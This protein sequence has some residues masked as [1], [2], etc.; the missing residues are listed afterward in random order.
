MGGARM[1]VWICTTMCNF[2]APLLGASRLYAYAKKQGFDI[3]LKDLNQD[4]Y[5]TL[6]SRDYLE[7][8]L[9]RASYSIDSVFQN[10]YVKEDLGSIIL[11]SSN[12]A[13]RQLLAKGIMLNNSWYKYIQNIDI[14]KKPMFGLINSKIK[15][16]NILYAL[17]SEREFFL[18]E[19][20]RSRQIIDEK[21]LSL[22]SDE[23][24]ENFNNLLCGKALIDMVHFPAMFDFG[25]GLQGTA[26]APRTGDVLRAVEDE[27]HNFLIPY[28]RNKVLPAF[29]EEQPELVG[30]SITC[31]YEVIPALTLANMIKKV[32]P[33]THVVLG[34]I[35]TTQLAERISNNKPLWS[36]FDSL[37]L[38]P[39][40]V[41][42][43]ELINQ[44]EKKSDFSAVPNL[45]WKEKGSI[46]KSEKTHEFDI[47]EACAPEFVSVRPNSGL[48]L[49]TASGC[50]WGKCIFCDYPTT[51]TADLDR[52]HFK[53][54]V[55]KME[56]VLNDIRELK[57]KY[58]P[59]MI[60]ITDSSMHPKRLEAIAE[61]NLRSGKM[62][63]FSA[64]FRTEKE[65]KSK[66]FCLKLKDGGFLGGYVGLESGSQRV[67]DI[68]NK[69]IDL[70]DTETIIKNFHDTDILLHIFSIIG[71]PGETREDAAMT[72]NFFKR[73]HRWLK[74]DWIIY[75]LYVLE[76]SPIAKRAAELGV[77]IMPLPDDYLTNATLYRTES[78]LSQDESVS[79]AIGFGEKLKKYW[80]PL[81]EIMDVESMVLFLLG[82]S[83][84]GIPPDKIKNT[85]IK[86]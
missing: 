16:D 71:I 75:Y 43:T 20:E 85:G 53:K 36:M 45:I 86:I 31:V 10:K 50:Y 64:L 63:K 15:A 25:L 48:P 28:Y 13:V 77:E 74:L 40:E 68:I 26:Y 41:A 12:Q 14:L 54:R 79:L 70:N 61:D 83:A 57:E 11:N 62:V 51:G 84:K 80:H 66:E 58:N 59:I 69:G 46:K 44:V 35:F 72:Y 30:I 18:S 49:E 1:T 8:V 19:I 33:D 55:R 27:K 24:I 52:A 29:R 60:A 2:Y 39:G 21:F 42:F 81:R 23:F 5:F 34:G 78:G 4:T 17:L 82:Q 56:L 76:E 73:W 47:N 37:V 32:N 67:N 9:E 3:R 65:F 7:P 6:L 38:G 22:K